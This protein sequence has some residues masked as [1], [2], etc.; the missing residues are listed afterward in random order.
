MASDEIVA[1][2]LFCGA[3]GFSEGLRQACE[4]LGYDLRHAA[5]NHWEPA[6][7]TH[8]RNHPDAHQYHSKVEQL[9]PPNVVDDLVEEDVTDVHTAD[10]NVDILVAGPE[11]THFSNARGD[12]PVSEQ[13][14]MSP[15][16]VLDWIQKLDVDAFLVENVSEIQSWGPVE[17]GEPTRDGSVFEAWINVLNQLGYAV[18]WTT[19]NAADFGD[20]TSRERF[21]LAGRQHGSITFPE[22]THSDDDAELPDRRTAAEIIDWSDLGSSIWTRDL[23]EKRVHSPPKD[24]TMERIAEG[25]RRHCADI[26]SPFAD[27]LEELGRDEIRTL[28]SERVVPVEYADLVASAVD[29]PFLV[30][31]PDQD[32]PATSYVLGQHS[33]SVARDVTERPTPTVT[34]GGKIQ[35]CSAEP[36][37]VKYYGTSPPQPVVAPLDAVTADG[38]KYALSTSAPVLLRQQ[39]GA[40]PVGADHPVPTIATGGAHSLVTPAMTHLIEPKNGLYRGLHSNPLYEPAR[41]PFHT[42]TSDPRAKLVSPYLAP[43]YNP[44]G[45]QRPRTRD[46]DR[47]LMTVPASKSPAALTTPLVRPFVDDFEND[48]PLAVSRPLKTITSRDKFALCVPELWPYGLDIK[49]RMLQPDELKQAQGFPEDYAISGTKE[50]KKKQIGNAVPVHLAKNLCKHVLTAED[51]SLATYGGGISGDADVDIPD[52]EEVVSDD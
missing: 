11:C 10:V 5:I 26:L 37:L 42:V 23:T 18:D 39:D 29:E 9:H 36:Y 40:H 33:N 2:D 17:D 48:V 15:W 31:L 8:E 24:T 52:Y 43:L 51:P 21:F 47:P 35:L 22:P 49:Y 3:G 25:I 14:R 13:K 38:N 6:V 19:L 20:P 34:A 41:R 46:V 45:S 27:V 16:Q 44:S 1:V 30:C 7:E 50:N 32:T 28:R 4:E 12:K